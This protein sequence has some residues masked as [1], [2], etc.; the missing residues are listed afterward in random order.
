VRLLL[1]DTGR[2]GPSAVDIVLSADL[3]WS[4]RVDGNLNAADLDLRGSRVAQVRLAGDAADI[5]L[6]MPS[7]D[8]AVPVRVTGGINRLRI[9][10][11][12]RTPMR[13]RARGGAGEVV[14]D[15]KTV[16]GVARNTAVESAGWRAGADGVD[17]DA[18]AGLGA[19]R[20]ERRAN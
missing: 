4:L 16:R 15:G 19:L 10:V 18:T 7:P 14:L 6:V 5:R 11:P 13:V 17:V 2:P 20:A 9:S 8:G 1:V 3:R 12:A